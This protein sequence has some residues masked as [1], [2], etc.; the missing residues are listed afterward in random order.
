VARRNC[1]ARRKAGAD[2]AREISNPEI[3]AAGLAV[4]AGSS[5]SPRSLLVG[6]RMRAISISRTGGSLPGANGPQSPVSR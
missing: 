3:P 1:R 6:R 2:A 4:R 5:Q